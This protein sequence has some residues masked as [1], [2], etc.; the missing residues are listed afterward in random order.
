MGFPEYVNGSILCASSVNECSRAGSW[1]KP[2]E[3]GK[4]TSNP[5][6]NQPPLYWQQKA[7][8]NPLPTL[9][10]FSR[11]ST[12]NKKLLPFPFW[13]SLQVQGTKKLITF[14]FLWKHPGSKAV[15]FPFLILPPGSAKL[16]F[17]PFWELLQA[18]KS[19]HFSHFENCL[20]RQKAAV[21]LCYCEKPSCH[22]ILLWQ[23]VLCSLLHLMSLTCPFFR[24]HFPFSSCWQF[25]W[26]F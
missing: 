12:G 13:K 26:Q 18:T 4:P 15:I 23:R 21:F 3:Q 11:H 16:S 8:I 17:F 6:A 10:P 20:R 1:V 19:C 5:C 2:T 24:H 14:T 22:T 9:V 25:L 7:V